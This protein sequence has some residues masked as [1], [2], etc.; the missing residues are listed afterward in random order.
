MIKYF[1]ALFL[2]IV[3]FIYL[4]SCSDPIIAPKSNLPPNTYLSV[5]SMPG[6]TVAPG[7][8][9]KKISWWGDSPVGIVVGFKISFDSIN[10]S[11]TS[12][13]DSTFAFSIA[14]QDSLFRIWVAAVDDKGNVDPTPA[15]NL[16]PVINSVPSMIFDPAYSIPD[17][18]FPIA[19]L[20]WIG[21]D[22]DGD[23]TIANYWYSINDTLHFKPISGSL[24]MMTLTKD[25]GLAAGNSCVYMKAQD[26]AHAFSNIVR[27]PQDS[28]KFFRVKNVTSKIL[29]IKDMPVSEF[30][31]ADSYFGQV[32]DTIHYDVLD[33]KSNSGALIPKIINPMFVETL[34]LFRIV[35]WSGNKNTGGFPDNEP[36]LNLAQ[37]SLPYFINSG[38]K[39]LWSTGV[40]NVT[41]IQGSLFNFAPI[42]S[43]KT[44][45]SIQFFLPGDSTY[46][47]TD[48]SIPILKVNSMMAAVKGFYRSPGSKVIF[49]I[50]PRYFCSNDTLTL[51]IKNTDVNP[52]VVF[53]L[54]PLYY[55]NGDVSASKLFIWQTIIRDFGYG[56][57]NDN[58]TRKRKLF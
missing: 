35:I 38:G 25:S 15:S 1:T 50:L 13:N 44:T 27:M 2:F 43:V 52:N 3:G 10:W 45:C 55:L 7:R 37:S 21:T 42:D 23:G 53:L 18:I 46:C 16:Y 5:F 11:Y 32:M 54:L 56:T 12:Q 40:P 30:G 6:D 58:A 49:Q 24:N 14:G 39:V 22:P 47:L 41:I 8:T 9:V 57:M 20:K 26:N 4:S 48:N 31:V 17:T 28:S 34:K 33:I 51:G 36:N 29:L 19:T